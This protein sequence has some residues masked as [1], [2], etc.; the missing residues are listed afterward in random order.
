[1]AARELVGEDLRAVGVGEG[2]PVWNGQYVREAVGEGRVER[3]RTEIEALVVLKFLLG[4][5]RVHRRPA[6]DEVVE[7]ASLYALV[8]YDGEELVLEFGACAADFVD[9]DD[10]CVPDALR[11]GEIL[12]LRA[13]RIRKRHADEVVIVD[14]ARVVE[15]ECHAEAF[16]KAF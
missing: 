5:R 16:G 7:R 14:E 3:L 13:G 15:A 11:G 9:E 1:M 10:L 12:Q 2:V 8:V 6:V 4:R